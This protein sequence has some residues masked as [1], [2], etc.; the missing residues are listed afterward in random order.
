MSGSSFGNGEVPAALCRGVCDLFPPTL[1]AIRLETPKPLVKPLAA[2]IDAPCRLSHTEP[3][4]AHKAYR[5]TPPFRLRNEF[6][7]QRGTKVFLG[8]FLVNLVLDFRWSWPQ[9]RD[10]LVI[11]GL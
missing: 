3:I 7:H 9:R 10:C 5:V 4:A 6:L 8:V 1:V 11:S 2:P